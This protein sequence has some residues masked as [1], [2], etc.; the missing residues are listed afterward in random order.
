MKRNCWTCRYSDWKHRPCTE[1]SRPPL[2]AAEEAAQTDAL[3]AQG[4][5]SIDEWIAEHVTD[6]G[7][8][9]DAADLCPAWSD[10]GSEPWGDNDDDWE[11]V[12]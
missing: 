3:L 7:T 11:D 6:D 12:P 5:T 10:G 9:S 1:A 4:I 8:V 2:T